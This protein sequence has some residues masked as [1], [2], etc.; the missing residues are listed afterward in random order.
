[1]KVWTV[2]EARTKIINDFSLQDEAFI[3][4]DELSGYLNDAI[5]NAESEI[6]LTNGEY[7]LTSGY[8][9]SAT[10]VEV[11]QLPDNI[12]AN[13]IRGFIYSNGSLIYPIKQYRRKQ[14]FINQAF[15]EE[16]GASDFYRYTLINDYP[17]QSQLRMRPA[18]REQAVMPPLA[19]PFTPHILWYYRTC[20]RVPYTGEFCNPEVLAATQFNTS[21]NAITVNSGN[22]TY[23]IASQG[24]AGCFPGSINYITGDQVQFKPGVGGTLPS[25]LTQGTVYF[26]I[27]TSATQISVATTLAN[28]LA[29]TPVSLGSQGTVSS[30]MTVAAEV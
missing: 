15:T 14:K 3:S 1:M 17:G 6:M 25:G 22:Q 29:N 30:I 11:Y 8:L 9:P 13:K 28:A 4:Y 24:V 20:T 27:A 7:F 5:N 2:L 10:G 23:G 26:V 12:Y 16:Y 18:S 21:T 19:N